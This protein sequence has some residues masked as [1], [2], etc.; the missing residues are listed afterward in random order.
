MIEDTS[1]FI[2][3]DLIKD[4]PRSWAIGRC[5]P[6]SKDQAAFESGVEKPF[7]KQLEGAHELLVHH[8][9]LLHDEDSVGI[10]A[11]SLHLRRQ[12]EV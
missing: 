7:E 9:P 2:S 11:V 1:E 6:V 12:Y 5:R 10:H 4:S 8:F 3:S